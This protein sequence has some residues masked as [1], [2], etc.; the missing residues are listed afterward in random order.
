MKNIYRLL[1]VSLFIGLFSSCTDDDID[2]TPP[3][4]L[5]LE[6]SPKPQEKIICGEPDP[7][8]IVVTGG[9]T[10]T[11]DVVITD[12]TEL[13]QLKID[14]HPNFDCHGHRTISTT[15]WTVLELIN[16]SGKTVEKLIQ[17]EVPE[18]V[19][20]GYYHLQ[21]RAV[22][23]SGNTSPAADFWNLKVSNPL[24]TIPPVFD[25]LSP[26][27]HP[28]AIERGEDLTY[29]ILVSDD[30]PLNMGGNARVELTYRQINSNNTFTALEKKLETKDTVK[31][32]EISFTI[33]NTLVRGS[34]LFTIRVWDGV[35]NQAEPERFE[36]EIQ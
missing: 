31:E 27:E 2:T 14:V 3:E 8:T 13:S 9:E 10:V 4:I 29:N 11:L 36:I 15:D 17:I 12:D 22:D 16:L 7:E 26:S 1:I 28:A 24:D 19:T 5:F 20:A 32:V 35:N 21:L 34:Y 18:L 23:K 30:Q 25:I 6:V 33:P